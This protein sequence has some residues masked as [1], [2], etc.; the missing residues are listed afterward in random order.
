MNVLVYHD[1]RVA[2][3]KG[4]IPYALNDRQLL[5]AAVHRGAACK[6]GR[7]SE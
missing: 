1:F 6:F 7:R 4:L 3:T 2:G 5:A